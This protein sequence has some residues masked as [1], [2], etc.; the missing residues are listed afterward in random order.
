MKRVLRYVIGLTFIV[1][2]IIGCFLP[3]LQGILFLIIGI[4]TLAPEVP[5]FQKILSRL[6][7]K[8]PVIF[9]KAETFKLKKR[10]TDGE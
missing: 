9:R 8:Y 1:L 7:E 2:G 6:Q 5:V 3:I 4:I 10:I